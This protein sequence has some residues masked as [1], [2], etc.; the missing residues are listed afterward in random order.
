M[1]LAYCGTV[2]KLLWETKRADLID[3]YVR[4]MASGECFGGFAWSEG[5]DPFSFTTTLKRDGAGWVLDG[6]KCPIAD[7]Q[8]ADVVMTFAKNA[9]TGDLTTVLVER[10]DRGVEIA[11]YNAMGLRS[12]GLASWAFS[13]VRL[14]PERVLVQADGLS[15]AQRFLNERRLEMCC[16][17]L[18]R[19]RSLFEAVTMDLSTRIRFRLPLIE[20][21][22]IQAAVGKMYVGLE[23]SRIVIAHALERIERDEYDW[24]WDPPLVVLKAHVIEQALQLCRTIQDVAGGYAVF[25]QAPYER[26]IRDLMC[27]NSIAG[28]LMTLAVDL[29]GLAAAEVQRKAKKRSPPS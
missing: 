2:T 13:R 9:A 11:P 23:T 21:Q 8:I 6:R 24:L 18:G 12:A 25:E 4:P 22:T 14:G 3:R 17:A 19:M 7:G 29:G 26:H 16:W 20:M 10:G 5:N 1:L 27:L 28:T 15:Y